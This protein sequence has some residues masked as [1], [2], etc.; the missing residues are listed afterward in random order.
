MGKT[1][2]AVAGCHAREAYAD[3][4]RKTWVKDVRG[5]DVRFFAGR[6]SI[7][8]VAPRCADDVWLQVPDGYWQRKLKVLA[9]ILWALE[10]GYEYMW[11]IDDDV[12][13]RPERLLA[14]PQVDYQGL[15]INAPQEGLRVCHGFLYGISL[16][17]MARL[18]F[19]PDKWPECLHE[20]IWVLKR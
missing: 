20:D 12:Y 14:L 17:S 10:R 9:M 4:Q 16:A 19:K 18:L 3:A 13:V 5:A 1:L 7:F 11:K 8:A 6:P 15:V 2:I